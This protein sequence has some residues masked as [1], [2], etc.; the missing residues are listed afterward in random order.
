MTR[1][2]LP[3]DV[4]IDAAMSAAAANGHSYVTSGH[5]ARSCDWTGSDYESCNGL[6]YVYR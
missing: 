6:G 2:G 4:Q 5:P 1:R 3:T